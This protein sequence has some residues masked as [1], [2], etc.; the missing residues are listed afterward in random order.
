MNS[1]G[2]VKPGISLS[3]SAKITPK[4]KKLLDDLDKHLKTTPDGQ[5]IL[6]SHL[7]NCGI[8]VM[9]QGLKDKKIP[10]GKFVG[11]G[12]KGISEATRQKDVNDF[13]KRLKKV[14][15]IS[16]AG[17]E[18]ISLNDTTWEG[19]LDPHYNPEKM[20]QMEARGVRS[21]FIFSV[22]S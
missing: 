5:A 14:M 1:I 20:K 22:L 9:E 2:S 11:K 17:G 7:I 6:F 8:D 18:G 4:T 10:Y 15:L 19:V 3:D 16:S 12:N 21:G 13:N